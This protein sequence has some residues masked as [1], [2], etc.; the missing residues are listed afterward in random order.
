MYVLEERNTW[1]EGTEQRRVETVSLLPLCERKRF[2]LMAKP[3]LDTKTNYEVKA[4]QA[5]STR[6]KDSGSG[7]VSAVS[8]ELPQ[9]LAHDH[10][11]GELQVKSGGCSRLRRALPF[12]EGI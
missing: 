2:I 9:A 4:V 3:K 12:I 11:D 8:E 10:E 1:L 5:A 6:W 7:S